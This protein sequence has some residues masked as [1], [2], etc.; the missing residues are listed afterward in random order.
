M[1]LLPAIAAW[2]KAKSYPFTLMTEASANL[3]LLEELMDAMIEAGFDTVFVGI[4]TPNPKALLK[5]KK[6]QNTSKT[7]ENYLFTAVR[8]IQQHGMQVQ[9]GF[10]LGLDGDGEGV[11]DAQTAFIEETGIPV[12]PIYLLTALKGTDM[13]ERMKTEKRLLESPIGTNAMPLNFKTEMDYGTL[14]EGYKRVLATLYDPTLEN[15]F[16]RCLTL[17][18]HLKSVPH[19]RKPKSKDEIYAAFMRVRRRLS[20]GQVPAY[21]KFIGKVSKDYPRMLPDAIYLAAMGHHFERIARQQIA[22]HDFLSFL[23]NELE[24]FQE[25]APN[26]ASEAEDFRSLG[27]T[28]FER[29][30][31]RYES[32]P[33]EF[34]YRGDGLHDALMYFRRLVGCAVGRIYA[35]CN[36]VKSIVEG[37]GDRRSCADTRRL[38]ISN[39][40]PGSNAVSWRPRPTRTRVSPQG[41]SIRR[42]CRP[43]CSSPTTGAG[44]IVRLS[45]TQLRL[46]MQ[47]DLDDVAD[48]DASAG[49]VR[50]GVGRGGKRQHGPRQPAGQGEL[51][52]IQVHHQGMVVERAVGAQVDPLHTARKRRQRALDHPTVAALRRHVAVAELVGHDRVLLRPQ[53]QHRL[54]AGPAVVAGSCRPLGRGQDG[55]IEIDRRH[56][57]RRP[58]PAGP[59][60]P[61]QTPA[62]GRAAPAPPPEPPS[63]RRPEAASPAPQTWPESPAP[64]VPQATRGPE[65]DQ[66]RPDREGRS[67]SSHGSPPHAHSANRLSHISDAERPRLRRLYR[68]DPSTAA[69]PP[70]LRKCS[71]SAGTPPC[72]VSAPRPTS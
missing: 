28:S 14:I 7:Q 54:V 59:P 12:A 40:A 6:S 60:P 29:A 42:C 49:T 63:G 46:H 57:L 50:R 64:S 53:R 8:R 71:I 36:G 48:L 51:P 32:I 17:F 13:Y 62:P 38:G 27:Q 41:I 58:R 21:S 65:E 31:Q 9:G 2:Q 19:L 24:T 52:L 67:R 3:A 18:G 45:A 69:A 55:G 70:E 72:A 66:A 37:H 20:A 56:P 15:Y 25:A 30:Q 22:I 5:T 34:R 16:R 23:R 43:S 1:N 44:S 26:P 39:V 68:T 47:A 61:P 11:F 4:E 35:S 33:D 10:I